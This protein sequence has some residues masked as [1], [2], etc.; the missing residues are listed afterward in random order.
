MQP[1]HV[2]VQALG[3]RGQEG[4]VGRPTLTRAELA[5]EER[6]TAVDLLEADL[7]DP[8]LPFDLRRHTLRVHAPAKVDQLDPGSEV[9][10]DRVEPRS[11]DPP[12]DVPLP[13]E[14]SMGRRD[15]DRDCRHCESVAAKPRSPKDPPQVRAPGASAVVEAER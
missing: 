14:V 3:D 1:G 5:Q 11:D 15:E 2:E 9:G 7:E 6:V 8:H 13:V 12:Q 4:R 10:Q